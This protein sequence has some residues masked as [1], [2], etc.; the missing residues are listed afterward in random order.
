MQG[1]A[2][3]AKNPYFAAKA[4]DNMRHDNLIKWNHFLI[5]FISLLSISFCGKIHAQDASGSDKKVGYQLLKDKNYL[6][7]CI[8]LEAY[9]EL[10]PQDYEAKLRLAIAQYHNNKI[11]RATVHINEILAVPKLNLPKALL[12]KA[13]LLHDAAKFTEAIKFYKQYLRTDKMSNAARVPV[14]NRILNCANGM[15]LQYQTRMNSAQNLGEQI[16]SSFDEKIPIPSPNYDDLVYFSSKRLG[17][18]DIYGATFSLNGQAETEVFPLELNSEKSEQLIDFNRAGSAMRFWQYDVA[19]NA[20]VLADTFRTENT[21]AVRQFPSVNTPMMVGDSTLFFANDS[22]LIFA[23][24]RL[25]GYGG[26]DLFLCRLLGDK[27][28]APQNLGAAINSKYDELSPFLAEDGLTLYFSSNHLRRS[29]GG[30][31]IFKCQ[32]DV[33]SEAWQAPNN[34]GLAINSAQDDLD[35]RLTKSGLQAFFSSNRWNGQGG[36]DIYLAYMSDSAE[37]MNPSVPIPFWQV[38]S[39]KQ[40][41]LAERLEAE[42]KKKKGLSY[43]ILLTTQPKLDR[44]ILPKSYPDI[45]IRPSEDGQEFL[46]FVGLYRTYRS[47]E[48][49]QGDLLKAGWAEAR[50]VPFVNGIQLKTEEIKTM[51]NRYSDLR[52]YMLSN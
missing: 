48:Q 6:Q 41:Q 34:L 32:F 7:A 49:L 47:A 5:L 25:E 30:F 9:N 18:W 3:P 26:Y 40:K 17:S 15:R 23:S 43:R 16:N 36:Q 13:Y 42:R 50:I 38:R 10:K 4:N 24:N 31:D 1:Q 11:D 2:I 37:E 35:F 20:K 19:G 39:Y 44:S 22:V 14:K 52:N 46:Y 33:E 12:Y 29:I 51:Q 28:S 21:N 8:Y 27:W 45:K